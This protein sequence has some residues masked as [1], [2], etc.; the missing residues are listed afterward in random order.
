MTTAQL[1]SGLSLAV[2]MMTLGA[3]MGWGQTHSAGFGAAIML[4]VCA[5]TE[6]AQFLVS[7]SR[8]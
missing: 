1:L 3:I 4:M 7:R 6:Y 5:A 2:R 8:Y